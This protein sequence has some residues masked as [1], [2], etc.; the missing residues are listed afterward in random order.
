MAPRRIL[1][2]AAATVLLMGVILVVA[3]VF[4]RVGPGLHLRKVKPLEGTNLALDVRYS[5]D[6]SLLTPAPFISRA[7]YPLRLDGQDFSFYG[8][9]IRGLGKMLVKDPAP[10]LYDFV[11]SQHMESFEEWFGLELVQD[12][13]YEDAEIQ[14]KLGLHQQYIYRRTAHSRGWPTYFPDCVTGGGSGA[15]ADNAGDS[16]SGRLAANRGSE[17]AYVEGWA[18]FTADDLF[19]FQAVSPEELTDAERQACLDVLNSMQFDVLLA[20]PE[21]PAEGELPPPPPAEEG[22]DGTPTER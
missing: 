14:G 10:L 7:E 11:G 9:R 5:Y 4:T 22:A 12:P 13:L 3:L 1:L 21:A 15:A 2:L 6:P 18:L 8:K 17:Y 19:F 16:L 20:T